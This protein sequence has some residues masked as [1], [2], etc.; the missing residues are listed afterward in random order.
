MSDIFGNEK[1]LKESAKPLIKDVQEP[2][3]GYI[4][5]GKKIIEGRLNK[6]SFQ[7]LKKGDIVHWKNIDNIIKTKIISI[8]HHKDFEKMLKAHR[9]YNVLPNVRTYKDGVKVYNK[10]FSP[11]DV[12]KY[13]VLAIK[14]QKI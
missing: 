8:H 9:L 12:K 6:G 13:G 7:E 1:S 14:I 11:F 4:K 5:S 2:W 3:F 10:F